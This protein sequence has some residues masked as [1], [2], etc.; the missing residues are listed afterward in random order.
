M[1][2]YRIWL[3]VQKTAGKVAV[4]MDSEGVQ[5]FEIDGE[6]KYHEDARK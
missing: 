3:R 6:D 1:L 4:D 5:V 2:L